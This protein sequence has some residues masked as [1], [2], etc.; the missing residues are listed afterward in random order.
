[1][2]DNRLEYSVHVVAEIFMIQAGHTVKCAGIN[3]GKVQLLVGGAQAVKQIE[4]LIYNPIRSCA[5]TVNFVDHNNRAQTSRERFLGYKTS[6]WHWPVDGINHQ[7]HAVHHAHYPLH[8]TTKI[9]V[10]RGVYDIDIVEVSQSQN[11]SCGMH[12]MT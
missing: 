3:N 2:I 5:R 8:F 12:S 10:A 1:M 11:Y 7:Q 9:R 4:N 6:L